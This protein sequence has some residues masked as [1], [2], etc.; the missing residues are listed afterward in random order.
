MPVNAKF[1]VLHATKIVS[2]YI[3]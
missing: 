3:Y 1:I 2:K